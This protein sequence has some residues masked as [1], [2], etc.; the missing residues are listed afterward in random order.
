MIKLD[1]KSC[2]FLGL[3]LHFL[4]E[5]NMKFRWFINW[6]MGGAKCMIV[7][8][9]SPPCVRINSRIMMFDVSTAMCLSPWS[10]YNR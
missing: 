8:L 1:V 6:D 4:L 7:G 2:L 9:H 10:Y 3:M 5:G